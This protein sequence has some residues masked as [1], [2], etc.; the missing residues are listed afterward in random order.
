MDT[1]TNSKYKNDAAFCQCL[2]CLLSQIDI[3]G[4]KYIFEI[5]ACDFLNVHNESS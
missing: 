2:H 4:K 3:Q 5:I 1:M